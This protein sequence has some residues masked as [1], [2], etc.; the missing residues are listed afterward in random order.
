M[1]DDDFAWLLGEGS[2]Y[3]Q[4]RRGLSVADGGLAPR[5]VTALV[6]RVTAEE[7]AFTTRELS[8][9]VVAGAEVVG[10]I[11]CT[12]PAGER[13]FEIGYGTAPARA[14]HGV[15]TAAVAAMLDVARDQGLFG[16]TA[17]TSISN[18][19]SQRVLEKNGF[20]RRGRR[21]DAQ[22]GPLVCWAHDLRMVA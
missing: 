10:M 2:G 6:R 1:T 13:R 16:L 3:Q 7:A 5:A 22:D 8:W 20:V 11:S 4:V 12:K 15:A 14:G 19:A 21:V 18:P 9:M 17:E